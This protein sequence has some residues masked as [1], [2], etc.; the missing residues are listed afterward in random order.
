MGSGKTYWADRLARA[1][2][3]PLIELDDQIS[4][5]EGMSIPEI[6]AA[7]GEAYFRDLEHTWLL[8]SL[9]LDSFVLSTGGGLPCYADH[10]ERMNASGL[11]L[12][13]DAPVEVLVSR[14]SR[15]RDRRPL[16]KDLD[17]AGLAAFVAEKLAARRRYY[18]QA[19]L[20]VDPCSETVESLTDKIKSCKE[21]F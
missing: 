8:E 9:K 18:A 7:R 2:E 1:L 6:F 17:D 21:P 10:M 20:I 5:S 4:R 13:L 16:L 12:W 19:R 3:L 15:G 11:T 14:L